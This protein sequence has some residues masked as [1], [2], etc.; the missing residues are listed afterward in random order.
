MTVIK[1][2]KE[3]LFILRGQKNM[4]ESSRTKNSIRNIIFS[5]LNQIITLLLG[6]INRSVFI[7]ILGIDY[8][9]ISGLFSDIL[10]ML[11]LADLGFGVALTY[12][13]YKPLAEHDY[14]R[15]AA[16][17]NLY[18]KVY[19]IIAL[20]VT[21]I[22]LLLVPFLKYLINLKHPIPHITLYYVMYLANTVAS[23]LVIYKTS[24]ITADQ[25]DYIL[26]KYRSYFSVLQTLFMTIFLWVTRNY[27]IYLL[28]QVI[29]TYAQNFYCS[30]VAS[31]MYPFINKRVKMPFKEV[32]EIF[33]NLYSVFLYKIS[34]VLLNATDN[35]IIS[36]M[37][38]TGMV[39][40]YSNYSMIT[41][42]LTGLI[43]TIF[44]SLTA[45]L[46]NLVVKE[47]PERRYKVFL[48]MQSVSSIF[49]TTCVICLMLLTQDFIRIWLGKNYLLSDTTL[50]AILFNFYLGVIL[51]PIWVYREA[52]GLYRQ[53][54]YVMVITAI[55]NLALSIY[56][57]RVMGVTGVLFAS[58]VARL[59]TY[60]WYEP[61]LL[62]KKY[63]GESSL[64]YFCHIGINMFIT[65]M[66]AG[67][68]YITLGKI[69]P[70][71]WGTF[72]IKAI[73][74]GI[75]SLSLV[76]LFYIRTGGFKLILNR[77]KSFYVT[78]KK[79]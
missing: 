69:E 3:F 30:H 70:N 33:Q 60:F 22:G 67:L 58:A 61:V 55:I 79:S 51:L 23:Y 5:F 11:S 44:Y 52:T 72:I 75:S 63:F 40:Y 29:F 19:R 26:N 17:T 15:L 25:K 41:T 32:K 9:G 53:T 54:K 73:I 6:L 59:L 65:V 12:S 77:I 14:N 1:I 37:I 42:R 62:F 24:I 10:M 74:I 68:E 27:F 64:I 47:K 34:G 43:N 21:V 45:S 39:G 78:S 4:E 31:K 20:A 48:V 71:N 66:I 13:M 7:W 18:R 46:G 36:I 76:M 8:L 56:L 57:A 50:M 16:L 28:V 49:S 2:L 38:G 35:T